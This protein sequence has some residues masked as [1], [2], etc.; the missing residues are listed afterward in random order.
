[1]ATDASGAEAGSITVSVIYARPDGAWQQSLCVARETS[2]IQA[3]K[4]SRFA[5]EFPELALERLTLGIYGQLCT[6]DRPLQDGDRV[7][8]YR[9][10]TFDAIESRRRRAIHR[11]AFITKPKNRPKRRKAKLAAAQAQAG[12][13]DNDCSV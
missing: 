5:A 8:I 10:L 6:H 4:A 3:V 1:M 9:P 7:E 12:L 2:A 13:P 11:Q